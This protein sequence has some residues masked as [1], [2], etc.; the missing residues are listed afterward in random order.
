MKLKPLEI[1]LDLPIKTYDIDFAGIVSNIV[2]IRWLEDLRLKMFEYHFPIEKLMAKGYCPTVNSTEIKYQKALR[3]GDR[4]VGKMWMSQL[5]R[6][7][8]SVQ[9]EIYLEGEIAATAT[10]VGFFM[11]L[12]S[13]RPMAIPEE[14]KNIYAES[15]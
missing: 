5:G 9:A 3:L 14:I 12:E 11:S 4:P 6:L 7:R 13:M 2:Y 15:N 10:Q 8:C 1:S